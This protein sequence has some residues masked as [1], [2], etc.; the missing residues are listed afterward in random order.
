MHIS[1]IPSDKDAILTAESDEEQNLAW[2]N[3]VCVYP[4]HA[5]KKDAM[6]PAES[7]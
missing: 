4:T 5:A 7:K 2:K 1:S 6:L 3:S